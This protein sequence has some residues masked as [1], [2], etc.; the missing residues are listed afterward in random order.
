MLQTRLITKSFKH[1]A[2]NETHLKPTTQKSHP[3]PSQQGPP[4][5]AAGAAQTGHLRLSRYIVVLML[6]H[7]LITTTS[8]F[9]P[10]W[11]RR[12]LQP[13]R[14]ALC[15]PASPWAPLPATAP[16]QRP[17][18][19]QGRRSAGVGRAGLGGVFHRPRSH[20]PHF[21]SP[22]SRLWKVLRR[23][24]QVSLERRPSRS[25]GSTGRTGPVLPPSLVLTPPAMAEAASKA[26]RE[27]PPSRRGVCCLLINPDIGSCP[28]VGPIR[29][30]RRNLCSLFH[31]KCKGYKILTAT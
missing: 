14:A 27:R 2:Y 21:R 20:K 18:G 6:L 25:G 7:K 8:H 4:R 11:Q 12:P 22:R 19:Q 10:R 16:L 9:H 28:H 24:G 17:W 29:A 1:D 15:P 13:G 30:F 31:L 5:Q 23:A 3:T 26:R